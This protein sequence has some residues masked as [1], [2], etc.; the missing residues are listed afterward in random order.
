MTGHRVKAKDLVTWG[1]ATHYVPN[2]RLPDLIK[3]IAANV[4][5][6]TQNDEIMQLVNK[7]ADLTASSIQIPDYAEIEK[8]FKMDSAANIMKRLEESDSH[9][10]QHTRKLL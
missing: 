6:T 8:I 7:H 5:P 9:F 4:K 2:E 1:I 3:S 10:A